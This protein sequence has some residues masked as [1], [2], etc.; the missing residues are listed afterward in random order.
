M[1]KIA[2]GLVLFSIIAGQIRAD[3]RPSAPDFALPYYNNFKD[4]LRLSDFRGKVA[5]VDFWATWCRPCRMEIP[6]FIDLY[7]AYKDSGFVMIGVALDSPQRVTK[8][9]DYYK[10]NYHVV[11]GN[12]GV[13][14]SFGGIRG[15]P[16]TFVIDKAGR[17]YKKYVG[18]RPLDFFKRDLKSLLKEHYK[19]GHKNKK[20]KGKKS[21]K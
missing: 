13:A 18:Y 2:F 20:H 16:T 17:I 14:K 21:A 7:K 4:T 1:K 12:N 10:M 5:I 6:G 19:N 8:F 11:I 3:E 9:H 15:I